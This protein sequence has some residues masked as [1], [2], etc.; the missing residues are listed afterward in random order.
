MDWDAAYRQHH[1]DVFAMLY[2][3]TS[4]NR[5]LARDLAQDTFVRA[6]KGAHAFTDTGRGIGP[7]LMTIAGNLLRDHWKSSRFHLEH[8][9]DDLR[10]ADRELVSAEEEMLERL[11]SAEVMRAVARLAP[12]QREAMVLYYWGRWSD[13]RIGQRLGVNQR[14]VLT[15]RYRARQALKPRLAELAGVA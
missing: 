6:I 8:V 1:G 4:G 14:T 5:E 12:E 3:R 15:R 13:E 11:H 7:W 9:T 2:R 10:A